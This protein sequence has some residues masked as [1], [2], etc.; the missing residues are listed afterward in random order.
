MITETLFNT[1][2]GKIGGLGNSLGKYGMITMEIPWNLAKDRIGGKPAVVE[3]T[4]GL[5]RAYLDRLV[6]ELPAPN[7]AQEKISAIE[8]CMQHLNLST[9]SV[10]M[11][12]ASMSSRVSCSFERDVAKT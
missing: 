2:Y 6:S 5:A 12:L 10:V 4:K 9:A 3:M 8:R 7:V 1:T 11:R